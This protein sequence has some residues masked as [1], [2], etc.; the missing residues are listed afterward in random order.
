MKIRRRIAAWGM[1]LVLLFT[2]FS[3]LSGNTFAASFMDYWP[4]E[5]SDRS[6]SAST[7]ESIHAYFPESY[8]A[9]LET[10]LK[11]HPSW[12]FKPLYT[13]FTWA[14]LFESDAEM[15]PTR[16][17][18]YDRDPAGYGLGITLSWYSTTVSGAYNWAANSWTGY[19]S[20]KWYQASEEAVA[21]C[22]DPRNFFSETQIF[23]FLDV[24]SPL[25]ETEEESALLIASMLETKGM[26]HWL[27][28]GEELNLYDSF[29]D[30]PNPDYLAYL[31]EK[32]REES[33]RASL[34]AEETTEAEESGREEEET[35]PGDGGGSM[36]ETTAEG[37]PEE[38]GS[39]ES[40]SGGEDDPSGEENEEEI[41]PETIRVYHYVTY[42][43]A[44]AKICHIL[45]LS[46]GMIVT[47]VIQEQGEGT[48]PLISGIQP[49]TLND[50]TYVP[51]GYYNYFNIGATGNDIQTIIRNGL[52]EAYEG[53]VDGPWD[54]RYKA[55]LGGARK[56]RNNYIG[57]GQS[58]LYLQKF[59]TFVNKSSFY[60]QYMQNL[61]APQTECRTLRQSYLDYLD[62]P[63]VFLIPVYRDMPEEAC[64]RPS[65]DR[66]PNYKVGS[67]FVDEEAVPGFDADTEG[68]GAI[69]YDF[70]HTEA[71]ITAMS[72]APTSTVSIVN[73]V[74]G[75][76][77]PASVM[78]NEI[79][80]YG[81][82]T[83]LV[84]LFVG[85][86]DICVT[87][88][89]ENED[90][91]SY[92]FSIVR[93][94]QPGAGDVDMDGEV[95]IFDVAFM[96]SHILGY[97]A[98]T[99][100]AFRLADIDRDLEVTIFDV[101]YLKAYILGYAESV[102]FLEIPEETTGEEPEESSEETTGEESEESSEQTTEET[103]SGSEES[104]SEEGSGEAG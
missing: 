45:G 102:E 7:V 2:A 19:D 55:L 58:T 11:A 31:E 80:G 10:L 36:E 44:L 4:A 79:S 81:F 49:F 29:E 50:G 68:Y 62:I 99:G 26:A 52:I 70:E 89:A 98:L 12:V 93:T 17:L 47:R 60:H 46:E 28:S 56:L 61:T 67:I 87:C 100:E 73:T 91:K 51:G 20:G 39:E 76:D 90:A 74:N 54:T 97:N 3:S 21:Y 85:T 104:G 24:G 78:K 48:S 25:C 41:P 57:N 22:L 37:D 88:T 38:G 23:Q 63:L 35:D 96:K 86:N 18:V 30:V 33:I 13:G 75:T 15:F 77:Y 69:E 71:E 43:E 101:A 8:W 64:P 66:N 82:H 84:P 5:G 16:N 9:G 27:L 59:N 103:T 6:K 1:S 94:G 42:A 14:R 83:A 53:G 32:A 40:G 92:R 95:S 72:Y 34:D 65:D